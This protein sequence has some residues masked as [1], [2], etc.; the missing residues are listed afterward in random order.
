MGLPYLQNQELV[1]SLFFLSSYL[2]PPPSLCHPFQILLLMCLF[3]MLV[4]FQLELV[5]IYDRYYCF[6]YNTLQKCIV[7]DI[8]G[9][10][11]PISFVFEV[12]FPY[13]RDNVRKHLIATY[14]TDETKD[15][16]KLLRVQVKIK[17]EFY[18]KEIDKRTLVMKQESVFFSS[19]S[20][21]AVFNFDV[22]PSALLPMQN[23]FCSRSIHGKGNCQLGKQCISSEVPNSFLL[24]Y[25]TQLIM[26]TNEES[27]YGI[28]KL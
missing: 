8:E 20:V 4:H 17:I 11:T 6:L 9:T 13:A 27:L 19:F 23:W 22:I 14:D 28:S 7:L 3:Y 26:L 16:I 1:T 12:L 25:I 24:L 18:R 15:D 21:R 5:Y 2:E 10:T